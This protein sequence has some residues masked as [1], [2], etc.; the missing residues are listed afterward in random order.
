[1]T[2]FRQSWSKV[3]P[4]LH[5]KLKSFF[6]L[7]KG[8]NRGIPLLVDPIQTDLVYVQESEGVFSLGE[9]IVLL[10]FLLVE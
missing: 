3:C 1:M 4:T 10:A 9:G 8:I 2:A 7:P 6:N 5:Y